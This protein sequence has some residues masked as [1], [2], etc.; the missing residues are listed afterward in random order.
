M[1][2]K[3]TPRR[4]PRTTGGAPVLV[5]DRLAAGGDGVGRIGA[6]VAFAAQTA[7]GDEVEVEICA[8]R[9]TWCR[10][11]VLRLVKPGPDRVTAPCRSFGACGGCDWQHLAYPAQLTAKR[12]IVED[13]LRRIG[14]LDP[15][16]IAPTLPSPLEFGYRHRARLHVARRGGA[17]VFGFFRPGSHDVV[18]IESCPV[19]HPALEGILGVLAE[20][21]RRHPP[22]F[23]PCREARLDTGWDGAAVRLLFRGGQG[24]PVGLPGAAAQAARDAA[25]AR[26]IR[27]LLDDSRGEPLALGPGPDALV[28]TGETFTQINLRQNQALVELAIALGAPVAGEE[29]LDLCCGLGNLALP[30]AARG[31]LVTGVDLDAQAIV[32]AQENAR[33]LGRA[34]NFVR[35][36]VVEAVRALAGAGRGFPLVLLNPPRAGAREAVAALPAL[37]PSRVVVVSCDPATLA[38]DAAVLAASGYTLDAVRPV[39]LFPQTAHVESVTLFRRRP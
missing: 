36:D 25:A 26:G 18:A 8:E 15:P 30:A 24:E 27:L 11:R 2:T 19:L 32:Q 6:K 16:A 22:A 10:A 31:A 37:S 9:R 20:T 5:I 39:D 1:S 14:R 34:A 29:V 21:G 38:R 33:R 17:A 4:A 3:R 28:T 35:D 7:P 13:A 23:A 12:S